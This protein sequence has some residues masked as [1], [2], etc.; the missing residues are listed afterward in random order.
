MYIIS[1]FK[2]VMQ[3]L[4]EILFMLPK[5]YPIPFAYSPHYYN[6]QNRLDFTELL[7]TELYMGLICY[8][9]SKPLPSYFNND[10]MKQ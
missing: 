4:R 3:D 9:L 5:E 7:K 10:Q 1:K 8:L 6:I 2:L